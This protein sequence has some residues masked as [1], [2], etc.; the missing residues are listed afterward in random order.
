MGED[1]YPAGLGGLDEAECGDRL[2]GAGGVLEPEALGRVGVLRLLAERLLLVVLVD[3]VPGLLLGLGRRASGSSSSSSSGSSS[4]LVLVV[5]LVLIGRG[6]LDGTEVVVLIAHPPRRPRP[7]PRPR[8]VGLLAAARRRHRSSG[9]GSSG[10]R[11]SAEASSSGEAEAEAPAVGCA[12]LL[13]LGQQRGQRAR[14]RVDLVCGE[15]GAVDELGLLLREHALEPQQQRELA[16]PGRRGV[17]DLGSA[18]SSASATS[19][20]RRRGVP[21]ARATAGSS[22]SWTKRSRTSFSARAISAELGMVVAARATEVGSAIEGSGL[23]DRAAD[24]SGFGAARKGLALCSTPFA[25]GSGR[26]GCT[27]PQDIARR[28][29][30][31]VGGCICHP[32]RRDPQAPLDRGGRAGCGGPRGVGLSEARW[33]PASASTAP[34]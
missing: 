28:G 4:S 24:E 30:I 13:R 1:Q 15:D 16:P 34:T 5:L 29:P 17:L 18:A 26:P 25:G 11:M 12:A 33:L 32:Y 2:A 10:P 6:T 9:G 31:E 3:P 22:P 14:E 27:W 8:R 21:G 20:A 23:R 19:S 7:P